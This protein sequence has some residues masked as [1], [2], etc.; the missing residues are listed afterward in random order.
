MRAA[1]V[2]QTF[3][4]H[5]HEGFA[6]GVIEDGALGFTYR[7]ENVVAPAGAINLANPDEPHTGYAAVEA[8]WT[9]R[10][11]YLEAEWLQQA[12]SQMADRAQAMPFFQAGVL[13]DCQLAAEI[14]SLHASLEDGGLT[15][16]EQE[17]R[18]LSLLSRLVGRHADAP[19]SVRGPAPERHAVRRVR[20]HIQ[21]HF[22]EAISLADLAA[23][24][25]LSPYHLLRVFHM[26]VG[27]PPHAYLTQVRIRK[28]RELLG[29]GWSIAAVAQETGFV[30]QSHLSRAFKRLTG[31]TPGQ[32][33]KIVQDP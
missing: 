22:S 12:A 11:F 19:P 21:T 1:Y 29:C 33:R 26:E 7:G 30:D 8:G 24:A 14:R 23:L 5:S 27:M 31:V 4:R 9:Y 28:A 10:M 2:T 3:P 20:D 6:V 15:E 16:I 25:R 17:S 13:Y 32:Y 18:F